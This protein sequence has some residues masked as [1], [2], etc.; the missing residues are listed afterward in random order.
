MKNLDKFNELLNNAGI[1][2]A[3]TNAFNPSDISVK[4]GDIYL[5]NY[6]LKIFQIVETEYPNALVLFSE[7]KEW[8]CVKLTFKG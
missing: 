6:P 3:G 5:W 8:D 2:Y 1:V 4:N 7:N